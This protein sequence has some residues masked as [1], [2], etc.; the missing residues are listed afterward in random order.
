[1]KAALVAAASLAAASAWTADY[2]WPVV[3]VID[4]DTVQVDASA[5]IPPELASIRVRLRG[6]DTPETWKPKCERERQAGEAATAFTEVAIA[7]ARIVHVRDPAWGKWGGR[8][9]ADLVLDG[10]SLSEA[11]I[12]AGHAR[13]Y[14]G[15]KRRNWCTP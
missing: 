9:V 4:G 5:D 14:D 6:V 7:E 2:D 12:A 13:S 1:M 11:L 15:G 8:V 10:Q 3:R